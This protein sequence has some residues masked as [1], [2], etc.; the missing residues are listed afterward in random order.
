MMQLEHSTH[1]LSEINQ[2]EEAGIY[3]I[4]NQRE[5]MMYWK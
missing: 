3:V 4:N 2:L 5:I 1:S